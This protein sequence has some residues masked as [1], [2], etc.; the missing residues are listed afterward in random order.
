MGKY[1]G[2][3]DEKMGDSFVT[4][5]VQVISYPYFLSLEIG[6]NLLWLQNFPNWDLWQLNQFGWLCFQAD[7]KIRKQNKRLFMVVYFG[8]LHPKSTIV[9]NVQKTAVPL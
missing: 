1:I 2:P 7:K 9:I 8:F 3:L 5:S 6:G 4:V